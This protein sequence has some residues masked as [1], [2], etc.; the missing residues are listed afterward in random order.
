MAGNQ[1]LTW[2]DRIAAVTAR[3][4]YTLFAAVLASVVAS[5]VALHIVFDREFLA[6][7]AESG[8]ALLFIIVTYAIAPGILGLLVVHGLLRLST[9][10]RAGD[11]VLYVLLAAA[12]G[13]VLFAVTVAPNFA[14]LFQPMAAYQTVSAA[15]G[16]LLFWLLTGRWRAAIEAGR[17]VS[18]RHTDHDIHP[19][20]GFDD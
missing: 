3:A 7:F 8:F 14:A 4:L 9:G 10:S 6:S 2:I 15:F 16:G 20:K 11:L 17:I 19:S 18:R 13:F 5:V 1:V 12:A